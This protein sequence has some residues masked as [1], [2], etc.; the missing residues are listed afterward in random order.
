MPPDVSTTYGRADDVKAVVD[1]GKCLFSPTVL[2]VD[3]G[4]EVTWKNHDHVPHSVTGALLAWGSEELIS[5]GRS[6]SYRFEEEGV[7]PYYCILHPGMAA[8]VIVGDPGPE[9]AD[10]MVAPALIPP[11][12]ETSETEQVAAVEEPTPGISP[13]L[14]IAVAGL[15]VLIAAG[16]F[17]FSRRR[18]MVP[19]QM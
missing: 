17:A 19:A 14:A 7:Y 10:S 3:E 1:T 12:E 8:A 15:A 6:V 18:R 4:T 5:K 13:V 9:T 16:S 11:A 2:Y